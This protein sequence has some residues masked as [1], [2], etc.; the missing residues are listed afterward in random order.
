MRAETDIP[1]CRCGRPIKFSNQTR[2]EDCWNE[3]PVIGRSADGS[4]RL[5]GFLASSSNFVGSAFPWVDQ[6]RHRPLRQLLKLEQML[7]DREEQP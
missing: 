6:T 3:P 2:C 1:I 5:N 4:P 7:L